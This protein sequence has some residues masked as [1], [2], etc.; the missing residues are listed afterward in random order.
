M[1]LNGKIQSGVSSSKQTKT[2]VKSSKCL[3]IDVNKF[4]FDTGPAPGAA[5]GGKAGPTIEEVD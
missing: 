2:L 1:H 3:N 5:A 4:L